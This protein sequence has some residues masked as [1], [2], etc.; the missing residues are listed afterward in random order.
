MELE[1]GKRS[2]L[3]KTGTETLEVVVGFLKVYR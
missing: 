3:N 2:N 1:E